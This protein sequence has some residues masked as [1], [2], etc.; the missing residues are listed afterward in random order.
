MAGANGHHVGQAVEPRKRV[1]NLET[2][3]QCSRVTA[4]SCFA[5]DQLDEG[6]DGAVL[7]TT[8]EP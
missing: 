2:G 4:A 1:A 3:Q 8:I 5:V 7:I 6:V